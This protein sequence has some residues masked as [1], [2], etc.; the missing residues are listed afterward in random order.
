MK[1]SEIINLSDADLLEA[2]QTTKQK[3]SELKMAHTLTPLENPMQIRTHRRTVARL[4]TE[5]SKR[6][7]V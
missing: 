3:V 4:N 1:Q 6:N 5:I 2:Y 7:L